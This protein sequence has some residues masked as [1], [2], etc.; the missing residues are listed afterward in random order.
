L[1]DASDA[2]HAVTVHGAVSKTAQ[3]AR[4]A[5]DGWLEVEHIPLDNRPFAIALWIR[6]QVKVM[7]M[8][9]LQ[10]R[11]KD[12]AGC[13]L[14]LMLRGPDF[15]RLGFYVNDLQAET[16]V[17]MEMGWSHLVFQYTG[18]QQEIWLNGKL[19]GSR[20]CVA[21]KGESG[22]TCI[23]QAPDWGANVPAQHFR[24]TMRDVR[25]YDL[26]LSA[27]Q[28]QTLSNTAAPAKTN[29][30]APAEKNALGEDVF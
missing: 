24:G 9:V 29:A 25:I 18:W 4:F 21:Y 5:G 16:P 7:N 12:K 3:G 1:D 14:H 8:G 6:P 15:P 28:I 20:Q 10:Q 30:P 27:A 19:V 2:K 23:G 13:H 17:T 11:D 22:L 26:A